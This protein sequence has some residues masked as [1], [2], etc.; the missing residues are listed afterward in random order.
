MNQHIGYCKF[1]GQGISISGGD[2]MT[3]DAVDREATLEC[4]CDEARVEAAIEKKKRYA[5]ANIRELFE[6]DG[7][8]ITQVLYGAIDP[9]ARQY[10]KSVTIFYADG[11]KAVLKGKAESISV[12]RIETVKERKED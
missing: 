2:D 5:E 8:T 12:E 10:I 1:C 11:V 4:A 9:V 3:Q 6:K 7:D